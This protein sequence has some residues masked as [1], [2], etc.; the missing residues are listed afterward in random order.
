MVRVIRRWPGQLRP[1]SRQRPMT[2]DEA[3]AIARKYLGRHPFPDREFRWVLVEAVSIGSGWYFDYQFERTEGSGELPYY[4][5]ARGF[6]VAQDGN[7]RD[8]SFPEWARL[9][10]ANT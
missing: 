6:L 2:K 1:F 3:T 8:I 5:G 7:V 10:Q 4:A 9:Q